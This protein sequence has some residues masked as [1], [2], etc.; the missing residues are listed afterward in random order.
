MILD[1]APTR[2]FVMFIGVSPVNLVMLVR[3]EHSIGVST[4]PAN[5]RNGEP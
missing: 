3:L 5:F 1:Y 2:D 4:V